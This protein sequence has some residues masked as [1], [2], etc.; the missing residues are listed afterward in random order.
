MRKHET[1][2]QAKTCRFCCRLE[3]ERFED[4]E[5]PVAGEDDDADEKSDDD[6]E[7]AFEAIFFFRF[8]IHIMSFA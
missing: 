8:L 6:G 4:A 5:H 7:N 2:R 3:A 1:N